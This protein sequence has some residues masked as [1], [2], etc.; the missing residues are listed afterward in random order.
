MSYDYIT[1]FTSPNRTRGRGGRKITGIVIHWWDD[2][3]KKPSFDGVVQWLCRPGGG[4]SA[5]YV[6]EAGRVACLVATKDTAWHC[7]H[8]PSNQKTIGIECN[9]RMSSGDLETVAELVAD[10]RKVYGNLPL[11]KHS[12]YQDTS[13]PGTY[14]GKLGWIN[15]R[16]EQLRTGKA[17]AKQSKPST[18]P[19][20]KPATRGAVSVDGYWGPATTRALQRINRTPV[21]GIVSSQEIANRKYMP[22]ATG[23]W[24]WTSSPVGSQLIIKMQKAFGV[25]ADGI[26]GPNSVKAMQKYYRV[27][28]DGYMGVETV[29][30]MQ[31][32]INRQLGGK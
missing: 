10:I 27:T 29:K 32:A 21:D 24:E 12:D 20:T 15:T 11:S 8:Y 6:V 30:A 4:S 9:P 25:R 19:A 22:A 14:A 23:G 7:G 31:A 28:V 5:H 18:K 17:P 2:P 26:M 13:C 16:A 3:S 1:K